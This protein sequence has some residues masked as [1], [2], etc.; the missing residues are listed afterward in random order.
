MFVNK[1]VTNINSFSFLNLQHNVTKSILSKTG[2]AYA[3]PFFP[4]I[5]L[6]FPDYFK[7][8]I[9]FL[10]S[11]KRE[12]YL[13]FIIKGRYWSISTASKNVKWQ[14]KR[15]HHY[16]IN[17]SIHR[18][19]FN[20]INHKSY[21]PYYLLIFCRYTLTTGNER[22]RVDNANTYYDNAIALYVPTYITIF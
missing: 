20:L 13:H 3:F 14:K 16:K 11:L 22:T 9:S 19:I 21:V 10:T 6:F 7:K 2:F 12:I 17:I 1:N 15:I 18:S 5:F 8:K 4:N